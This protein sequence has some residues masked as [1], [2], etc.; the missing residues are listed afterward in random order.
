M[1]SP[2]LQR[3]LSPQQQQGPAAS[4]PVPGPGA[5][6][7][8]WGVAPR[9]TGPG[10]HIA[11]S[12]SPSVNSGGWPPSG[13]VAGSQRVTTYRLPRRDG[14][15]VPGGTRG[16][17]V[18][19]SL[20]GPAQM[21]FPASYTPIAAP[22]R[23]GTAGSLLSGIFGTRRYS[24]QLESEA[25]LLGS[26]PRQM[27]RRMVERRVQSR[28]VEA[29]D[30][31]VVP[32]SARGS[33]PRVS[34]FRL[35]DVA[36]ELDVPV[37]SITRAF[38]FPSGTDF[39]PPSPSAGGTAQRRSECPP[40]MG[41]SPRVD[42]ARPSG[43]PPPVAGSV[44]IA[45]QFPRAPG[46]GWS[47]LPSRPSP[48]VSV[49][50]DSPVA[51]QAEPAEGSGIPICACK[52][53]QIPQDPCRV[54]D[55]GTGATPPLL[56]TLGP[57]ASGVM[58]EL[59]FPLPRGC[60]SHELAYVVSPAHQATTDG[61]GGAVAASAPLPQRGGSS[62]LQ[63]ALGAP[64]QQKK[65]QHVRFAAD[66]VADMMV[67]DEAEEVVLFVRFT[68]P[69]HCWIAL[70]LATAAAAC[71]RPVLFWGADNSGAQV[72]GVYC[73]GAST[74]FL[75]AILVACVATLYCEDEEEGP[76]SSQA[77]WR[78]VNV[79]DAAAAGVCRAGVALFAIA[80]AAVAPTCGGVDR[81]CPPV[82]PQC[83]SVL[84][85]ALLLAQT[86]RDVFPPEWAAGAI[87][88]ASAAFLAATQ[89]AGFN[90][91]GAVLA[92][93]GAA[94]A[95]A[96]D[97]VLSRRVA[98]S[99]AVHISTFSVALAQ[100][101]MSVAAALAG[102]VPTAGEQGL[103]AIYSAK[104]AKYSFAV[105]TLLLLE[106]LAISHALKYLCPLPVVLARAAG[107]AASTGVARAIDSDA[108]ADPGWA[109]PVACTGSAVALAVGVLA[110]MQ[111]R[112][113]AL[114]RVDPHG[115]DAVH[116]KKRKRKRRRRRRRAATDSGSSSGSEVY[117]P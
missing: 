109:L 51:P 80:A 96:G 4:V 35:R 41:G 100:F 59:E 40:V 14:I 37:S 78:L 112:R 81:R 68:H 26:L 54:S 53:V 44:R 34:A 25:A 91:A 106:A 99:A 113:E 101:G 31:D 103:F 60:Q 73:W 18:A 74:S 46:G 45:A 111:H 89:H 28:R 43:S 90:D 13:S 2:A 92:A 57:A 104:C 58:A 1:D 17:A 5:V 24:G 7:H 93:A 11:L 85:C 107:V 105:G 49:H 65:K 52:D 108:W 98:S 71:L 12:S 88:L 6:A 16:P 50:R 36:R 63:V 33:A 27:P 86:G 97:Y 75:A 29:S 56:P 39:G 117:S 72:L 61:T 77:H 55:A 69:W 70:S 114:V 110:T 115:W 62:G 102:G 23:Q 95:A 82:P 83:L 67:Y 42:L 21:A 38:H 76:D 19:S 9:A 84:L 79:R 94:V 22:Q 15:P 3:L 30:S 47:T 20:G 116:H 87:L 32:G 64:P 48:P 66:P 10:E 8:S